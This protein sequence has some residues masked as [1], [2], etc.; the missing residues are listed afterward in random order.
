MDTQINARIDMFDR[1]IT[2][3]VRTATAAERELLHQ[4]QAQHRNTER[5]LNQITNRLDGTTFQTGRPAGEAQGGARQRTQRTENQETEARA[6]GR[7]IAIPMPAGK[8]CS[9]KKILSQ[10]SLMYADKGLTGINVVNVRH[11]IDAILQQVHIRTL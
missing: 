2:D 6:P 7:A 5:L 8:E 4:L 11:K 9:I 10:N 1:A 3:P